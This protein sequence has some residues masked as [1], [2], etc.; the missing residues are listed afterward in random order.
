M[1][2]EDLHILRLMGEIDRNGNYTQRE[3]SRRLN[4]SLGLV[5]TFLKRLVSK[6]YFKVKTMPRNRVKYFLTPEGLARKSKLTVEYLQY[7]VNF[8]R[9]IKK[10]L[11]NKYKEM[12]KNKVNS[13][14]F[15]GAG[16]VAELAYLYLQ[17]TN[18]RLAGII[19]DKMHGAN[20]FGL[21]IAGPD[22]INQMQWDM[23]LLTRLEDTDEDIKILMEKGIDP[24]R[25]ATI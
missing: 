11:I 18:I 19:D 14:L 13:V 3:L 25:I 2:K 1:D 16:E 12:E 15:Y 10:L 22:R 21:T 17:L 9:D 5:N 8:Y 4:L 20:F 6:G 23:V 24:E 7:S